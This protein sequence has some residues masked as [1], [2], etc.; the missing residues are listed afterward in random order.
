LKSKKERTAEV[1]SKAE[2]KTNQDKYFAAEKGTKAKEHQNKLE[3]AKEST[4]KQ[5]AGSVLKNLN[6]ESVMVKVRKA[7][8]EERK[9]ARMARKISRDVDANIDNAR[10]RQVKK[11]TEDD[12]KAL[13]KLRQHEDLARTAVDSSREKREKVWRY[14][15]SAEASLDKTEKRVDDLAKTTRW[16]SRHVQTLKDIASQARDKAQNLKK[17]ALTMADNADFKAPNIELPQKLPRDI[18]NHAAIFDKISAAH[19]ARAAARADLTTEGVPIPAELQKGAMA[20]LQQQ[21]TQAPES[22]GSSAEGRSQRQTIRKH[23]DAIT[24]KLKTQ[25][26]QE[27]M[28]IA[29]DKRETARSTLT[30]EGK[31]IPESLRKGGMDTLQDRLIDANTKATRAAEGEKQEALQAAVEKARSESGTD[32][33]TTDSQKTVSVKKQA[34]A[35]QAVLKATLADNKVRKAR[36]LRKKA[37]AV[38][39]EESKD[40]PDGLAKGQMAAVQARADAAMKKA[41][42]LKIN[43]AQDIAAAGHGSSV[44]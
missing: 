17:I 38:L 29:R 1:K 20:K 31:P 32:I 40:I 39:T 22:P 25:I 21:V 19:E 6:R 4:T 23:T 14:K 9:A 18:V 7:V 44:I 43:A 41:E 8:E 3:Q 30:D 15:T 5:K 26:A 33:A 37:R 2:A 11:I 12:V 10:L 35:T 36:R 28:D 16:E 13:S 24:A 34:L 42:I 27:K